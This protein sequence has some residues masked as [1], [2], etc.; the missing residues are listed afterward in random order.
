[1]NLRS[2][3]FEEYSKNRDRN[4]NLNQ[5]ELNQNLCR[6]PSVV[7]SH[8]VV[9]RKPDVCKDAY[10]EESLEGD[11]QKSQTSVYTDDC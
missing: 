11:F 7:F 6:R 10:V 8:V 2:A 5:H 9:K 3:D 1:M 4:H